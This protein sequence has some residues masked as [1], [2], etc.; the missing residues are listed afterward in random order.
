MILQS[1]LIEMAKNEITLVV[2]SLR[3]DGVTTFYNGLGDDLCLEATI[4]L[5][6]LFEASNEGGTHATEFGAPLIEGG[7]A[8]GDSNLVVIVDCQIPANDLIVH[9][10]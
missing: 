2:I 5:F 3:V 4:F 7:V 6:Q 9:F 1:S 8:G 10:I